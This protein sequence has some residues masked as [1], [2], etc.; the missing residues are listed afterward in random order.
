MN[1]NMKR[2]Y[3]KPWIDPVNITTE[4]VILNGSTTNKSLKV[5]KVTVEEYENGFDSEPGGFKELNFD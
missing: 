2:S 3:S 4:G 5:D 1:L